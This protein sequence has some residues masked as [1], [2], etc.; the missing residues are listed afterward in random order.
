MKNADGDMAEVSRQINYN[1]AV[2]S[3]IQAVRP[4]TQDNATDANPT[5]DTE[6]TGSET[7]S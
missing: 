5:S 6:K 3:F 7:D 2:A 1:A 4:K